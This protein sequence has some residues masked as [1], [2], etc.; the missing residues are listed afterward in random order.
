LTADQY[1]QL[2]Q[3]VQKDRVQRNPAGKFYLPSWDVERTLTQIFGFAGWDDE[4]LVVEQ[5]HAEPSPMLTKAGEPVIDGKTNQQKQ[6]WTI[7]V[8]AT[9]VLRIKDIYGREL[10]HKTGVGVGEGVNQVS[11]GEAASL[12][13]K[14]AASDALKRA[15]K[16]L[17][18]QFG[19]SLYNIDGPSRPVV[20]AT[21]AEPAGYS[22]GVIGA[23][24]PDPGPVG[25]DADEVAARDPDT[26]NQVDPV[27]DTLPAGEHQTV[28]DPAAN[29]KPEHVVVAEAL[30]TWLLAARRSSATIRE[31][32]MRVATRYPN[33]QTVEVPDSGGTMVKLVDLLHRGLDSAIAAETAEATRTG[34]VTRTSAGT[35][36]VV[37]CGC[38]AA[39]LAATGT[40][41]PDCTRPRR[42]RPQAA[43]RGGT[44]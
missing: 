33:A 14:A 12:A 22:D 21:L 11:Y 35:P 26:V 31:T 43:N 27:A 4:D 29:V 37:E 20:V 3:P 44:R 28:T 25:E 9:L 10:T 2:L 41:G 38:N 24:L 8:R 16:K 30:A 40:H 1:D 17:G 7:V 6:R 19:L 5:L 42:G 32:A 34:D 18:D 39:H 36:I 15:A 23:G 13:T